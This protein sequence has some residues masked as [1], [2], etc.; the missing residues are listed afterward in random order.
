MIGKKKF[1]NF[2]YYML[3]FNSSTHKMKSLVIYLSA[4]NLIAGCCSE[5]E[6]KIRKKLPAF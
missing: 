4:K 3:E 5:R 2:P 6:T 1:F